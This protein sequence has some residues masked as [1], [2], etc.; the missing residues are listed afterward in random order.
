MTGTTAGDSASVEGARERRP[1]SE[2]PLA[3]RLLEAR[4]PLELAAFWATRHLYCASPRGD[5]HPVLVLPGFIAGDDSTVP[6]RRVLADRGHAVRGW[7]LGRNV[8]PTDR[9]VAGMRRQLDGMYRTSG[10]KVSVIGWSLGGVYARLLA[11]ERPEIIRQVITLGSPYRIAPGDRSSASRMW[12]RLEPWHSHELPM[13]GID[14]ETRP[15]LQVP[16]TSIYTRDDGVVRWQLCIDD[17]G[18]DSPNPRAE[19][20]EVVGTHVGLGLNPSVIV[21]ILDRLAV[22][23]AAWEPFEPPSVVRWWYP[24]PE[25]WVPWHRRVTHDDQVA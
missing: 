8:G 9:I 3:R 11:R 17:T 5:G 22:P 15:P 13:L 14:E 19:N 16:A 18:P 7:R 2:P 10:R 23:E 12:E 6:L 25:S 24:T 4:W 21:A 1:V 20:I